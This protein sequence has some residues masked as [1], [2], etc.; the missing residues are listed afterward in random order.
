MSVTSARATLRLF[1]GAGSASSVTQRLGIAP[2]EIHEAG[3]TNAS[4]GRTW[5]AAHW[6]ITSTLPEG[7]PLSAHLNQLLDIVEPVAELLNALH[8]EGMRMDWFCYIYR[9]NGQGG[10]SFTPHLLRRLGALPAV[11]DLDIY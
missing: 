5:A 7:E 3:E 4:T 11:L 10:P 8:Q 2:D 1:P 9:D 6:S